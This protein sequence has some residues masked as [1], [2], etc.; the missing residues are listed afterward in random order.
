MKKITDIAFDSKKTGVIILGGGVPKN[1]ILQTMLIT[2]K[3]HDY[4]IQI[5]TDVPHWGGLSGSTIDEAQSWGKI[6]KTAS[7]ATAYIDATIGLPLIVGYVLQ[8]K[9]YNNRK[10]L[11]FEWEDDELS[12]IGPEE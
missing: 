7:K 1:F 10:R 11:K 4:A 2:P 9:L 12:Y 8:K 3:T 5:T 6:G